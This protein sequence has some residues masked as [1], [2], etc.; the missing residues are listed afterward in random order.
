MTDIYD[1]G[2]AEQEFDVGS[3]V[4]LGTKHLGTAHTEFPNS[5]KLRP[6]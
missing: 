2:L 6:K 3:R 4:Y 5:R 1:R